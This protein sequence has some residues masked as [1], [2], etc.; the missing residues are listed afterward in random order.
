M[1]LLTPQGRIGNTRTFMRNSKI[2]TNVCMHPYV[3]LV[4]YGKV[5]LPCRFL[6]DTHVSAINPSSFQWMQPLVT[7][8]PKVRTPSS[9]FVSVKYFS[10]MPKQKDRKSTRLNS[11]HVKISYA[12]FC[13][14][15]K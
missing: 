3:I 9:S 8:E 4:M 2:G 6:V 11:S 10:T 12:V 15:K 13:L 14:K 7:V 5:I 1:E